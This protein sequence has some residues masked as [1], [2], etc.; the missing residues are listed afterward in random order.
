MREAARQ[1]FPGLAE[2]G[3]D[4]VLIARPPA[5]SRQFALLLDDMKR[6]LLRL[7]TLSK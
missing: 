3:T 4:Y 5:E 6:A 2:L 7:N 1:V